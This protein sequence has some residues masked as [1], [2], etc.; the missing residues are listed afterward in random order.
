MSYSVRSAFIGSNRKARHA[1]ARQARAATADLIE[2]V[3]DDAHN[4]PIHQVSELAVSLSE[5]A[6]SHNIASREG[7]EFASMLSDANM[8]A[9][10]YTCK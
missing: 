10:R 4:L 7:A 8:L 6:N 9:G 3:A 1:G 2:G 5:L